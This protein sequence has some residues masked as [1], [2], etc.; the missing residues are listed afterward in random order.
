MTGTPPPGGTS[1]PPHSPHSPF[2]P[3][4]PPSPPPLSSPPFPSAPQPPPVPHSHSFT[5]AAGAAAANGTPGSPPPPWLGTTPTPA[6]S[7]SA[8]ASASLSSSF[9]STSGGPPTAASPFGVSPPPQQQH[10]Y[11]SQHYLSA[12]QLGYGPPGA[13]QTSYLHSSYSHASPTMHSFDEA[14]VGRVHSGYGPQHQ[15]MH[16]HQHHQHHQ[17]GYQS[18]SMAPMPY[19]IPIPPLQH[20]HP[21]PHHPVMPPQ[22][23]MGPPQP[24]MPLQPGMNHPPQTSLP[25]QQPIPPHGSHDMPAQIQANLAR[26]PSSGSYVSSMAPPSYAGH[27][28]SLGGSYQQSVSGLTPGG[29]HPNPGFGPGAPPPLSNIPATEVKLEIA[30]KGLR[31]RDILTKSDPVAVVFEEARNFHVGSTGDDEKWREIGRTESIKDD[32]NPHFRLHVTVPYRFEELQNIRIGLWDIDSKNPALTNQDFLGDVRTT[33]GDIVASGSWT[34]QLTYP[35]AADNRTMLGAVRNLGFVTVHVHEDSK[36]EKIAVQF[37]MAG[38][39]LARMDGIIFGKSDPYVIVSQLIG[40]GGSRRVIHTSDVI[41]RTL[42]PTWQPARV[43]IDA[44]K[45]GTKKDIRVEFRVI[46]KDKYTRDDEIGHTVTTLDVLEKSPM[47]TLISTKHRRR[48][49]KKSSGTLSISGAKSLALPTMVNYLQGGLKLHFTVAVDLTA[50]NGDPRNPQSLHYMDPVTRSNQYVRALTAVANII[51]IYTPSDDRA[52]AFG[53][54]ADIDNSGMASHCFPLSLGPDPHVIGLAGIFA[55]YGHALSSCTLSGPT[56]FTPLLDAAIR[57]AGNRVHTQREQN[58]DVLLILTD[59]V[60]SD[61]SRTIDKI[62]ELSYSSAMSI[63]IIGV[64]NADFRKM[65]ILDGD[66]RRL[67]SST[68]VPAKVDAVQFVAVSFSQSAEC[69]SLEHFLT[70]FFSR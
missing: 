54:G 6:P 42:N 45:G 56:N 48:N 66:D 22:P 67:T 2:L 32:L 19:P 28:D 29:L 18:P 64:G 26:H 36:S 33:L 15:H 37:N 27:S 53:F 35:R 63:I 3:Q 61:Q 30:C 21:M 5:G 23:G 43:L 51:S 4:A 58:Y 12:S 7:T 60:L 17:Q 13:P 41:H 20:G 34:K 49:K 1:S 47:L 69:S 31:D 38:I 62:V 10:H 65:N 8:S 14:A 16:E 68:G 25:G 9:A 24:G 59:G 70:L 44:P 11:P 46:D 52:A 50:S 40:R 55:A 39:K 57:L